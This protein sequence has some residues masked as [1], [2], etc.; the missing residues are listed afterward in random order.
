METLDQ[1]I[2]SE[3]KSSTS[4]LSTY[5]IE[6]SIL[7]MRK[8]SLSLK[9]FMMRLFRL[10][11]RRQKSIKAFCNRS[12]MKW[13]RRL[14]EDVLVTWRKYIDVIKRGKMLAHWNNRH[15]ILFLTFSSWRKQELREKLS[16]GKMTQHLRTRTLDFIKFL[17]FLVLSG[18][19]KIIKMKKQRGSALCFFVKRI[20]RAWRL[21][22][23]NSRLDPLHEAVSTVRAVQFVKSRVFK[24]WM[25]VTVE[26][27]QELNDIGDNLI[28][29]KRLE[30]QQIT[31]SSWHDITYTTR[32]ARFSSC[33]KAFK[34]FSKFARR[35]IKSFRNLK[36]GALRAVDSRI[37]RVI[38]ILRTLV[39]RRKKVKRAYGTLVR[40]MENSLTLS[41]W[42]LWTDLHRTYVDVR[43]AEEDAADVA[44]IVLA[45]AERERERE[46]EAAT[47][48]S[49]WDNDVPSDYMDSS[50]LRT[51]QEWDKYA[52]P[53]PIGIVRE[54]QSLRNGLRES[55]RQE[56][57]MKPMLSASPL[58]SGKESWYADSQ[59]S[60][61]KGSDSTYGVPRR[62]NSVQENVREMKDLAR[63]RSS[64]TY[65]D[66]DEEEEDGDDKLTR[67]K[68]THLYVRLCRR[69]FKGWCVRVN[70]VRVLHVKER[71][72]YDLQ[73]ARLRRKVFSIATTLWTRSC[74]KRVREMRLLHRTG[75]D[76][77]AFDATI[78][79]TS[80]GLGPGVGAGTSRGREH[81]KSL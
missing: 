44:A 53:P 50:L 55:D 46:A 74:R 77:Q 14:F 57:R 16:K 26:R 48:H 42:G 72:V 34:E 15:N 41:T 68:V 22:T 36:L 59:N 1:E 65:P 39:R 69:A 12:R 9:R 24:A 13:K 29:L 66:E 79:G 25:A 58:G 51:S 49:A 76:Q 78:T 3:Q 81:Y 61:G 54:S 7:K 70:N 35:T 28:E 30:Q 5:K 8:K 6:N 37:R 43:V 18:K 64:L 71:E 80:L 47:E 20:F 73:S 52:P 11:V 56:S 19:K 38:R 31:L 21:D 2:L 62:R 4:T 40:R 23:K 27:I 32:Y 17:K 67:Y 33:R 63:R 60:S 45:E 75:T 10:R